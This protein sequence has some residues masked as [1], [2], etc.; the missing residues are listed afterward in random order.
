MKFTALCSHRQSNFR[1]FPSA[2]I[3]PSGLLQSFPV[4]LQPRAASNLLS[5]SL[6]LPF[7]AHKRLPKA[8]LFRGPRLRHKANDPENSFILKNCHLTSSNS[9]ARVSILDSLLG[10]GNRDVLTDFS[11][12]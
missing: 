11:Y 4:P 1:T 12:F 8:L 5:A 6:D 7:L 3:H 2:Q 10:V 9:E